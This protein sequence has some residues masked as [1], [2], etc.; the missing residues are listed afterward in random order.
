M[1]GSQF[2]QD[3]NG[4]VLRRMAENGDNQNIPRNIDFQVILPSEEAAENFAGE[5]RSW[6]YSATVEFPGCVPEL[7]WEVHV[8]RHM[9]PTHEG[10]TLFEQELESAAAPL[11]GRNDGW[12][13]FS[14]KS[15]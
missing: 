11:G 13:C 4:D 14:V 1:S 12:G 2:P 10:I 3:E 7:P 15:S 9:L 6:D 5:V 8:V